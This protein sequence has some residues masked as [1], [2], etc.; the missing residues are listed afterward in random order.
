MSAI[1]CKNCD[2]HFKG[3]FCPHCGQSA[4]VES[5]GVKYFLHDIPHSIFH[6]DKGF[7]YTLGQLFTRPGTTIKNYL[8]GKRIKHFRPFAYVLIL[9]AAYVFLSPLIEKLMEHIAGQQLYIAWDKRPFLEHYIS[10]LIFLLIPILSF[11]TW[12]TFPKAKYNYWEHFLINTYLGAQT[13][14][15]LLGIKLFGLIKVSL[16]WDP[17]VN[18]TFA[19]FLFMT[20]YSFTFV[21]LMRPFYRQGTISLK[22]LLMNLFLAFVYM[23]G[24]SVSGIMSPWWGQ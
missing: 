13:N 10:L 8:A 19:M 22:L 15:L 6:I 11:V 5:I 23:T 18:F 1:I 4:K 2:H 17:N 21:P 24:F 14:I 9:S 7:F 12:L 3:N 16:K 20:Y